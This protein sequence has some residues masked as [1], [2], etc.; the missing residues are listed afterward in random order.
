[1][2]AGLDRERI[3]ADLE[4]AAATF[5]GPPQERGLAVHHE[6][7]GMVRAWRIVA[8]A[9]RDGEYDADPRGAK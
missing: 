1:M 3:L 5:G 8:A 6:V 4:R 2:T 9:I 7:V